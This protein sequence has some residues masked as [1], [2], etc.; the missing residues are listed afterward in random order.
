MLH[1]SVQK[2]N[3]LFLEGISYI[4]VDNFLDEKL[5]NVTPL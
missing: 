5:S 3:V 1:A 4:T 2:F